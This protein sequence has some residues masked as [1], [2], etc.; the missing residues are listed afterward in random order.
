MFIRWKSGIERTIQK[1][2][3][4]WHSNILLH[5]DILYTIQRIEYSDNIVNATMEP[6]MIMWEKYALV[7]CSKTKGQ[8]RYTVL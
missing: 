3:E 2:Q 6:A 5:M 4:Q 8:G 1:F 7:F